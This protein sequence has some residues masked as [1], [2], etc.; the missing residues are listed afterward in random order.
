MGRFRLLVSQRVLSISATLFNRF[1]T[2]IHG[3]LKLPTH[4]FFMAFF[5]YNIVAGLY[6]L[7]HLYK[8][9]AATTSPGFFFY[10]SLLGCL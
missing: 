4:N 8:S 1:S 3:L 10:A 2:A 6:L 7:T 5:V 9:P